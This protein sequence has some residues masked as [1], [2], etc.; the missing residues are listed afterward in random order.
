MQDEESDQHEG[1]VGGVEVFRVLEK[2]GIL[3]LFL[4]EGGVG[5]GVVVG[6]GLVG[7]LNPVLVPFSWEQ[8]PHSV[9]ELPQSPQHNSHQPIVLYLVVVVELEIV[10]HKEETPG[11]DWPGDVDVDNDVEIGSH[12][13]F[14]IKSALTVFHAI[15]L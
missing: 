7:L 12:I 2:E 9:L 10:E 11:A 3:P 15:P 8:L 14:A 4:D 5:V 6:E 13:D 1:R